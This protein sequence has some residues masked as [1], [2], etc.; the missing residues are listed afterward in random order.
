MD[1]IAYGSLG[2]DITISAITVASM[3]HFGNFQKLLAPI[4][5]MLTAVVALTI[6]LAI[7]I[8]TLLHYEHV[9]IRLTSIQ[10]RVKERMERFTK[11]RYEY[12]PKKGLLEKIA[13]RFF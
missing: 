7:M 3:Y 2:L 10:S 12:S 13:D 11:S 5:L 4:N 6:L 8:V 9:Y 1:F